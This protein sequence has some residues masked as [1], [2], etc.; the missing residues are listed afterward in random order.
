MEWV[1]GHMEDADFNDPLPPPSAPPPAGEIILMF[2]FQAETWCWLR[3]ACFVPG[4]SF[5]YLC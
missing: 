4:R 2:A 1:L 5:E 3:R